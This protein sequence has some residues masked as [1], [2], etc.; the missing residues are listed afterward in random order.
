MIAAAPVTVELT[1]QLIKQL[2]N[3]RLG[4]GYGMSAK[5]Q[6]ITPFLTSG[7]YFRYDRNVWGRQHG[8]CTLFCAAF[9]TCVF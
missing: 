7:Q 1:Q 9:G 8:T 2:P 5:C 3:A 4:Q 6:Y